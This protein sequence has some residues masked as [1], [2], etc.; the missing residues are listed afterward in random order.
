MHIPAAVFEF[1]LEKAKREIFETE[2]HQKLQ[3]TISELPVA[4]VS[5]R[6]FVRNHSY[7]NVFRQQVHSQANQTHLLMTALIRG[8]VFKQRHMIALKWPFSLEINY[9]WDR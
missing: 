7:E 9:T 6:V 1:I 2:G 8:H 3:Q 4:S 5:N